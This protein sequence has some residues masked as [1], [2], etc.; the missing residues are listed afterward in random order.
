MLSDSEGF[1]CGYLQKAKTLT[2]YISNRASK[3]SYVTL[4][5]HKVQKRFSYE[6]ENLFDKLVYNNRFIVAD[7][8]EHRFTNP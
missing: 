2:L 6:H 7:L 4:W 5:R 3:K 8:M 1:P